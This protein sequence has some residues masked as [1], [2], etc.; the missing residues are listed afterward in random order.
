VCSDPEVLDLQTCLEGWRQQESL[1]L[2]LD[3]IGIIKSI[4]IVKMLVPILGGIN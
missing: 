4:E 2:R 3:L 1:H